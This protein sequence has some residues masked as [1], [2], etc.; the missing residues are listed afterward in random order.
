MKNKYSE[1]KL[2]IGGP[3]M[4]TYKFFNGMG[5]IVRKLAIDISNINSKIIITDPKTK[6]KEIRK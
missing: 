5:F 1:T 3:R 6:Y 2:I 4:K